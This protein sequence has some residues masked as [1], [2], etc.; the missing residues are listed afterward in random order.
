MTPLAE[1]EFRVIDDGW[2]KIDRADFSIGLKNIRNARMLIGLNQLLFRLNGKNFLI[3]AGLGSKWSREEVGLIDF[4]PHRGLLDGIADA[5]LKPEDIDVIIL[6]HLHYDHSGGLTYRAANRIAVTF[7]NAVYYL[8]NAELRAAEAT[9]ATDGDDYLREDWEP[10]LQSSRLFLIEGD[11]EISPGVSLHLA[12]GHTP[13]HQV[14]A[15]KLP[16]GT[17]LYSGDLISTRAHANLL[18]T[19]SYDQHRDQILVER[20]KWLRT[21]RA[22]GWRLFFCHAIKEPFGIVAG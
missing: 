15:A 6:S 12:P 13:G 9:P 10:I 4:R 19:M 22:G 8:Q 1:G 17:L 7:P 3:D 5:G 21:A 14:A 20:A 16:S 11:A 18:V 2:I